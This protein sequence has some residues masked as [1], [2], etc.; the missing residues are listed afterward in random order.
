MENHPSFDREA[1]KR[2]ERDGYSRVA[3]RYAQGVVAVTSQAN[4]AILDAVGARAGTRLLDVACGPGTLSAAA[5]RRGAAVTGLDLAATMLV[6]ARAR[7]PEG[8]FRDGDAENLPFEA[9]CFDAA[10]CS[11][12]LLHFPDPERAVLEALR[13]LEPG[14]AYAFTCWTPPARNPFMA[15]LFEAVQ[16]HGT[17]DVDLPPGPP[18][19]RLG[20]HGECE[21]ILGASGFV[22]VSVRELAVVW[23]FSAP[24]DVVPMITSSTARLGPMLAM[25]GDERRQNIVNAIADGARKYTTTEGVEIPSS[26]VLATGRKPSR[27][28]T[29]VPISR[30]A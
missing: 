11:C 8:D 24:E 1:F 3:E 20:E 13:V 23:R 14:G 25:Q 7:C 12:G 10:V 16:A 6:L 5:A 26:M 2:F 27:A 18:L 19:F 28:T 22:R 30:R 21:K 9:D 29:P 15:L 17:M 4:E